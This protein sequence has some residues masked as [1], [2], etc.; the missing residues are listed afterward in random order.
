MQDG[1][2]I[3]SGSVLLHRVLV[4]TGALVAAGA[5][6]RQ[7]PTC[8]PG[9][10]ALGV[11]ARIRPDSVDVSD[12]QRGVESYLRAGRAYAGSLRRLARVALRASATGPAGSGPRRRQA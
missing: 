4:R 9:A 1:C 6:S 11:P 8:R 7:G 10:T 2:L 5:W 3:G 12:I